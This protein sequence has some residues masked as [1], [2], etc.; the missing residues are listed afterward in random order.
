MKRKLNILFVFLQISV[1]ASAQYTY[2]R[3]LSEVTQTGWYR[4]ELP[5]A[6]FT[7]V[8]PNFDDLR[9]YGIGNDS[10]EIPYLV[11]IAAD[12]IT[13]EQIKAEPFN[14]SRQGTTLYFSVKLNRVEPVNL[15]ILQFEQDNYDAD[16]TVEGSNDQKEWF[17]VQTG[18]II[19]INKT[20]VSYRYNQINFPE[21][22]YTFLRFAIKNNTALTL[23][24]VNFYQTKTTRGIF[25]E[26]GSALSTKTIDK[27]S[28]LFVQFN[29]TILL[30]RLSIAAATNQLFY[31]NVAIDWLYDSIVS[32]TGT[33]YQYQSLYSGVISSFKQDTLS[34]TPQMVS[35]IRVTIYNADNPPVQVDKILAWSPQVEVLTHL[36]PGAYELKYGNTKA[37]APHYDLQHFVKELPDSLPELQISSELKP[38]QITKPEYT[39]W[40]KNKLWMWGA[41]AVIVAILGFFTMRMLRE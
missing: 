25:S 37:F 14:I 29:Q 4:F 1:A 28:E 41:L 26:V 15:A 6:M 32:E 2:Q 21:S 34:F 19:A 3:K 27:Q 13:R 10:T 20:P 40:F 39:P 5:P 30:S 17:T 9:I 7:K 22:E 31:R 16:I 35:K 36:Q 33:H 23:S 18:R 12:E 11:R 38:E 8:K 24:Q